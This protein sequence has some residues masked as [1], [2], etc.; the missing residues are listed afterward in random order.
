[1]DFS[2]LQFLPIDV[3]KIPRQIAQNFIDTLGKHWKDHPT[4][5]GLYWQFIKLTERKK[6]WED[7]SEFTEYAKTNLS[8]IVEWIEKN[9]PYKTLRNVKF[10][11]QVAHTNQHVD[12]DYPKDLDLFHNNQNN[13]P[14]GYRAVI[15][16]SKS[17]CLYLVN[18]QGERIYPTLPDTTDTYVIGTTNTLHGVEEE[19]E[20]E[21]L[22][23]H[24]EIDREEHQKLLERSL[25]KYRE[26][27]VWY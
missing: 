4:S 10:N 1:M 27:A 3:P 14:C 5:D 21:T 7:V 18:N 23:M 17:G 15:T 26:F 16:G 12:Y 2:K 13:E 20:R 25:E 11:R 24:F 22:Y 19:S 8:Q 9:F 6:N